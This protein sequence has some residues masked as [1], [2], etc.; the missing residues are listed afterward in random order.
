MSFFI[1][2]ITPLCEVRTPQS[3]ARWTRLEPAPIRKHF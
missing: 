1:D 2:G 3:V